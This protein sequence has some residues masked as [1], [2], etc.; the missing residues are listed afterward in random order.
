MHTYRITIHMLDGSKGKFFG[1]YSNSCQAVI[2]T[3]TDFP[4]LA[5]ITCIR[6]D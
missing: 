5:A 4:D 1:S 2:N 6:L 3:I